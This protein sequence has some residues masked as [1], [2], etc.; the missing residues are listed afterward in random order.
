MQCTRNTADIITPTLTSLQSLILPA[1]TNEIERCNA[2]I[3]LSL[4]HHSPTLNR[5]SKANPTHSCRA[6]L[7]VRGEIS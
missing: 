1:K 3:N 6:Q 7:Q 4:K 5:S 2:E